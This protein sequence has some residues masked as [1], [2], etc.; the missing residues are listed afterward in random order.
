[1]DPIGRAGAQLNLYRKSSM[2]AVARDY[3]RDGQMRIR[4]LWNYPQMLP[5]FDHRQHR[6]SLEASG[7][8]LASR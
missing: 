6:K 2:G 3:P 5:R 1:M 8:Q 7:G 4:N